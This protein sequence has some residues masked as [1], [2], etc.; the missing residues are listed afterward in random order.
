ME[1]KEVLGKENYNIEEI[2]NDMGFK[3]NKELIKYIFSSFIKNINENEDNSYLFNS[4]KLLSR[5]FKDY[6]FVNDSL[7]ISKINEIKEELKGRISS[8]PKNERNT[9]YCNFLRDSIN[10]FENLSLAL[11]FELFNEYEGD[12]TSLIKYLVYNVKNLSLVE[13]LLDNNPYAVFFKDANNDTIF[14][15]TIKEYLNEVFNDEN[16]ENLFYYDE[17]LAQIMSSKKFK[18]TPEL[19]NKS[20]KIM[21]DYL[22]NNKKRNTETSYWINSLKN[23]IL[24]IED[25]SHLNI[26]YGIEGDFDQYLKKLDPTYK[27]N[28]KEK[29]FKRVEIDEYLLTIDGPDATVLD[30]ALSIKKIKGNRYILGVHIADPLGYLG[31]YSPFI[32]EAC[33][34]V[35]S[36]YAKDRIIPLFPTEITKK[37]LSLDKNEKRMANSYYFERDEYGN[38]L[39]Y[40]FLKTIIKSNAKLN[41]ND[42]INTYQK[43]SRRNELDK[44]I[45]DLSELLEILKNKFKKTKEYDLHKQLKNEITGTRITGNSLPEQI[46]EY[47]MLLANNVIAS[48]FHSRHLPFIYRVH[49]L[50]K[51]NDSSI[52]DKLEKYSSFK[53]VAKECF[54]LLIAEYPNAR[55]DYVNLGHAGLNLDAYC[56]AT[57]PLRRASDIYV[58]RCLDTFYY[59]NPTDKEAYELEELIKGEVER[60]NSKIQLAEYY[61]RDVGRSKILSKKHK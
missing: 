48:Y 9:D 52:L 7:F 12:S 34:R 42:V 51:N 16:K 36:V 60:I 17:V 31:T 18:M 22:T 41:Y 10:R 35:V 30:D 5:L 20:Y 37:Y 47:T 55:Y 13:K 57:S 29:Q 49:T 56:H 40:Y 58:N 59:S 21:Q 43:N 61:V 53:P 28:E 46:V 39:D 27:S 3:D 24:N 6:Y 2:K 38:V 4:F 50:D 25:Y 19:K 45:D 23:R 11:V 54:N 1:F 44:S 26:K 32:E 8:I 14:E 15:L 33:N